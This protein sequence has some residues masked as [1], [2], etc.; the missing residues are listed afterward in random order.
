MKGP[1]HGG[2]NERVFEMLEKIYDHD[3]DPIDYVK[4]AFKRGRKVM[5]F[6]HRIYKH[7]DPRAKLLRPIAEKMAKRTGNMYFFEVQTEI[8]DYM[9]KEKGLYP[10]VYGFDLSLCRSEKG[11]LY[12]DFCGLQNCRMVGARNG[13]AS[14]KDFDSSVFRIRRT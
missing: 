11:C 3:M 1:L 12:D 13:T 6:G 7:G 2:A 5:G 9:L 8:A 10:N 4:D 14:R